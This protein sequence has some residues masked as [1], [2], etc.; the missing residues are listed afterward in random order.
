MKKI[1]SLA[2]AFV[3]VF[4]LCTAINV[5]AEGKID[6][7]Y[8]GL[9]VFINGAEDASEAAKLTDGHYISVGET[10]T[11]DNTK[12]NVENTF[13]V[14]LASTDDYVQF[15]FSDDINDSSLRGIELWIRGAKAT[16][17][18]VLS[19]EINYEIQS[20]SGD[21]WQTIAAGTT[22]KYVGEDLV[23]LHNGSYYVPYLPEKPFESTKGIRIVA[24][25]LEE[26]ESLQISE[27]KIKKTSD[28]ATNLMERGLVHDNIWSNA[29]GYYRDYENG[30]SS[31]KNRRVMLYNLTPYF[32]AFQ[33]SA[34]ET[35]STFVDET[36]GSWVADRSNSLSKAKPVYLVPDGNGDCWYMAD[37]QAVKQKI[38]HIKVNVLTGTAKEVSVYSC[39]NV[40][41][42]GDPLL[43]KIPGNPSHSDWV[44]RASEVKE[45]GVTDVYVLDSVEAR[46]WMIKIND[47]DEYY[48]EN[49][50]I[51]SF[52]MYN[53]SEDGFDPL[54]VATQ[55]ALDGIT[56]EAIVSGSMNFPKTMNVKGTDYT[57]SWESDSASVDTETGEVN[58]TGEEQEV[59]ITLTIHPSDDSANVRIAKKA[60]TLSAADT[61]L[62]TV[63]FDKSFEDENDTFD[64]R[65]GDITLLE[66]NAVFSDFG[67]GEIDLSL[68]NDFLY[69]GELFVDI[70]FESS[71][72]NALFSVKSGDE[73]LIC[74]FE[75]GGKLKVNA[76]SGGGNFEIPV[77]KGIRIQLFENGEFSFLEKIGNS[78]SS[79]IH[80]GKL[81]SKNTPDNI[82]I[83]TEDG[84]LSLE[85]VVVTALSD[86]LLNEVYEQFTFDKISKDTTA[87]VKEN[88][89]LVFNVGDVEI[90]Y[91]NPGE[92]LID[93]ESGVLD[94]SKRQMTK[95][96]VR[97]HNQAGT[98]EKTFDIIIGGENI[99]KG[100]SITGYAVNEGSLPL[101]SSADGKLET[102]FIAYPS[103]SWSLNIDL[104]EQKYLNEFI[105][106]TSDS[107]DPIQSITVEASE[108]VSGYKEIYKSSGIANGSVVSVPTTKAR[109]LRVTVTQNE[110]A[111][112]GFREIC[113]YFNP[114]DKEICENDLAFILEGFDPE[115]GGTIPKKGTL[116]SAVSVS[117]D[118]DAITVTEEG[119][120][121]KVT[122]TVPSEEAHINIEIKTLF[123]EES[124]VYT[125]KI[126]FIGS[127]ED[128]RENEIPSSD[129][130]GSVGK[131]TSN[132]F[133]PVG[134]A[135]G[136][137]QTVI[138]PYPAEISL[139]WAKNEIEKLID[140]KIVE[141][142]GSSLS[143]EKS[144]TRA[145]FMKMIA[146]AFN[147]ESESY[148]GEFSDV[149]EDVWYKDIAKIG[150]SSGIMQ[151]SD[152]LFR[153]NDAITREEMCVTIMRALEKY[154]LLENKEEKAFSD[155][156]NISSWAEES[157]KKISSYGII[158]GYPSGEF[159]PKKSLTRAEA[160]VVIYRVLNFSEK[161]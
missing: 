156:E 14:K 81:Y 67:K 143:L 145:E 114:T 61:R 91:F 123:N 137:V 25:N 153:G 92:E 30:S 54:L 104:T 12:I 59:N 86:K 135:A 151:G 4:P 107:G 33:M 84:A 78:Y 20:L 7:C 120:N 39:D 113:C 70:D 85:S 71:M 109:F 146:T 35:T 74:V 55:R 98:L 94:N 115:K 127:G 138:N 27:A 152:G 140:R 116:G 131:P 95:F 76:A 60:F 117:S 139:H 103:A 133:T 57:L 105:F 129:G 29:S 58:L 17:S 43:D 6:S 68:E 158:N 44:L 75:D 110:T 72:E 144:V 124:A 161:A 1:L 79:R 148:N 88:L 2:L 80:K 47:A 82:L 154:I 77:P 96:G 125:K 50:Q 53:E 149:G 126:I 48:D 18:G 5:S 122:V 69:K 28:E 40:S 102:G 45:E 19:E 83:E 49:L 32:D 42:F 11:I 147:M 112:N 51:E 160:M 121:W 15:N 100:A 90:S 65:E 22:P 130:G 159:M 38:N 106:Y 37:M 142:D 34:Y 41:A 36:Y 136:S 52:S 31:Y 87:E 73:T 93:P 111:E 63:L 9:T 13:Y 101:G 150:L 119:E 10:R 157:V 16:D 66:G 99:M 24:K 118:N 155:S 89:D 128:F 21:E 46:Y 8:E 97:L 3:M 23:R 132:L 62:K 141:G 26:G 64:S 56:D 108:N 134:S